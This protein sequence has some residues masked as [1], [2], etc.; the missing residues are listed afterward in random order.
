MTHTDWCLT[1]GAAGCWHERIETPLDT[2]PVGT[3][4]CLDCRL[5]LVDCPVC[6]PITYAHCAGCF[7]TGWVSI[8][9]APLIRRTL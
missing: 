1:C 6:A 9:D 2:D 8:A 4:A 3:H 5:V 7:G